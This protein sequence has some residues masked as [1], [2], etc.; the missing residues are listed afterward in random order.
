MMR[1][2]FGHVAV[3][4]IILALQ[5]PWSAMGQ[6]QRVTDPNTNLRVSHWGDQRIHDRWSLHTEIHWRRADLGLN[7]QQL[8]VRP[9]VNFHLNDLVLFTLGYS[10]YF[11]YQYGDHPIRYQNWE[12]HLFQQ[13]QL[14]QP[15]GRLRFQHRF[16]MEERY[17]AQLTPSAE[18]PANGEFDRY[19]Y[20]SRFRYRVW[21]T[22]PLGKHEKVEPGVF[23]ANVYDEVFINFG[24]SQRLDYIQ[25]NRIAGMLGYQVS[26]PFSLLL[27]FLYQTIERPKAANGADLLELNSTVHL[28]LV[29]NMD[30][31]KREVPA[32]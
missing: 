10:Y 27:G 29:Y 30:L 11:N 26:K 9:A 4:F 1:S 15:L 7:W 28:A 3:A 25:Q 24:D 19:A 8:L 5:A 17:I 18:D 23:S 2:L 14:T 32:H 20:Q 6:T 12:H 21:L 22:I 13:V 16:R 31:R